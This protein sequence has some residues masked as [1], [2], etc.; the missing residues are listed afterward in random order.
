VVFSPVRDVPYFR[1]QRA[2]VA[3]TR[4][5]AWLSGGL[6]LLLVGAPLGFGAT[7]TRAGLVLA[8]A[9]WLLALT[10]VL[11]AA[12]NDRLEFHTGQVLVAAACLLGATAL[13]WLLRTSASPLASQ[14]E[15]L[16]WAGILALAFAAAEIVAS[17]RRLKML[18]SALGVAG[19][20]ISLFGITQYLTSNGKIYWLVEPSQGGWIFGPYVNRNHFAG[21]MELWIPLA[22]GLALAPESTFFRRWMWCLGALVMGTAVALSGSRG[23]LL[24]V[25]IE[26]ALLVLVAAALRGRRALMGIGL[27]LATAGLMVALLGRGE[28]FERYKESLQLPRLQQEEAAARRLDAW[29]GSVEIF[30]QHP[31]LGSGLDTFVT[32][33]PAVRT[34]STDKI[35]THAHNDFLQFL[36]ETGLVGVALGGWIL[37]A[38]G[39]EAWKNLRRTRGTA[40][41]V[42]LAAVAC[43]CAGFM[44]HGWL[45]FNFHVPANAANFAVL[46]A[47]L[48]RQGW[49][50]D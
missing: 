27:A 19:V 1:T 2:P 23:G 12:W 14:Q 37:T 33:F 21:L 34:F 47:I 7:S 42:I 49:D 22:L 20:V 25:G 24:A 3:L 46:G 8:A 9:G 31:V 11:A 35:W 4:V 16:R 45:D 10:W 32:H 6:L 36:A 5:D 40:T 26:V 13:P 48:V 50:E 29:R 15:W 28:L 17:P 41:G 43:A 30:K 18:V 38:G 39:R 44:L